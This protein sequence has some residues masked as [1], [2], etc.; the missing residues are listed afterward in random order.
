MYFILQTGADICGF[1]G[2]TTYELCARWMQ[3]GAFYPY[4]RNH[5]GKGSMVGGLNILNCNLNLNMHMP[6]RTVFNMVS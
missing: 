1:F 4:A 2:N 6:C 5:N 3:L